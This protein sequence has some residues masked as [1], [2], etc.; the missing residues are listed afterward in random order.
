[1]FFVPL[2]IFTKVKPFGQGDIKCLEIFFTVAGFPRSML[3]PIGSYSNSHT[4]QQKF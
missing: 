1:M 4:Q 3:P 2:A